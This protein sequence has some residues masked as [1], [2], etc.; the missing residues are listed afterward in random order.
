MHARHVGA[1]AEFERSMIRHRLRAGPSFIKAK[2]ERDAKFVSKAGKVRKRLGQPGAEADNVR[3]RRS[4][5]K[6]RVS[7]RRQN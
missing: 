4:W 5:L 3:A 2:I 1:F 6:G 7:S